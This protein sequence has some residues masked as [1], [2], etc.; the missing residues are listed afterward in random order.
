MN[1]ALISFSG[2][3]GLVRIDPGNKKNPLLYLFLEAGKANNIFNNGI[4]VM[5][6]TG[7]DN[8]KKPVI[9][10]DKNVFDFFVTLRL[11]LFQVL[12]QGL[13]PEDFI[14]GG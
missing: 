6:G 14:Y 4:L 13:F 1:H 8:K 7:S 9:A 11:D 3:S 10:A 2:G 5:G 12:W